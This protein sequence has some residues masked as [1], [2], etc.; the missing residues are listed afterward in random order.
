MG[1]ILAAGKM[2]TAEILSFAQND[3]QEKKQIPPIRCG[4]TIKCAAE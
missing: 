1:L 4:M 3:E 2:A